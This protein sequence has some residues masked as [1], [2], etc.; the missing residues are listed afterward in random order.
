M[1][2]KQGPWSPTEEQ[3]AVFAEL[4]L[5]PY[6]LEAACKA[7]TNKATLRLCSIKGLIEQSGRTAS[8]PDN[9]HTCHER[10]QSWSLS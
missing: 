10:R 3:E 4:G 9:A 5:T 1:E 2:G 7:C 8:G 6:Q